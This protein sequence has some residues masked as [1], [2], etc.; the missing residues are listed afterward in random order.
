MAEKNYFL[1][2]NE[3]RKVK[4][5]MAVLNKTAKDCYEELNVS[6]STFMSVLSGR[7]KSAKVNE[8]FQEIIKK[9]K[10]TLEKEMR[11]W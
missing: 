1:S 3:S 9:A 7:Q 11:F 2:S 8:Y 6:K 10:R 5:A 4:I